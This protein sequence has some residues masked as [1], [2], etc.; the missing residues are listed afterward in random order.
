MTNLA[1]TA[2]TRTRRGGVRAAA[3]AVA[4]AGLTATPAFADVTGFI[5]VNTTPANRTVFGAAVSV[6]ALAI[7]L[8]GEYAKTTVD[9]TSQAPSLQT[10]MANLFVQNPVPLAGLQFYATIGGGLYRES[11]GTSETTNVGGN[12]GAGVKIALVSHVKLRVDYRVFKLAG[13]AINPTPKR[14]YL[15][16]SLGF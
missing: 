2:D 16:L 8:E 10:G 14:L 13:D 6:S 15:G 7:G 12:V 3:L 9:E 11:L 1:C 4:L 5:G